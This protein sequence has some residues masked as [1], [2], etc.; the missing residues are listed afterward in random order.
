MKIKVLL[1]TPF[2]EIFNASERVIEI[3]DTQNVQELLNSMCDSEE[4][5]ET[6]FDESGELKP[7]VSI[8]KNGKS[9]KSLDGVQTKL[10][11]G[12]ELALF[13]PIAGG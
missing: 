10:Q 13:P 6:L 9:V 8:L 7:Y 4:R 1:F 3:H 5:R 2:S 12:D 11:D